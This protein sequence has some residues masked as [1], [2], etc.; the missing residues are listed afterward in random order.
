MAR[1]VKYSVLGSRP[2][3]REKY[4]WR[5]RPDEI[6]EIHCRLR[7]LDK[8]GLRDEYFALCGEMEAM[9]AD[10]GEIR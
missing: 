7:S 6:I 1:P 4:W 5:E 3:E 10:R 2:R 8:R 9:L